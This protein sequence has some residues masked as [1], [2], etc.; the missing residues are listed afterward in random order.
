[1]MISEGDRTAIDRKFSRGLED[2]V[3]L[4][5]FVDGSD[6]SK[7]T[8]LLAREIADIHPKV[9]FSI[10]DSGGSGQ[11]LASQ[12]KVDKF[13]TVMVEK[14]G[15]DR[16][17]YLGIPKQY[18]LPS[19]TDAVVELSASSAKLSPKAKED[20]SKVR[21]RISVK[22]FVLTTCPYCPGVAR[23]AYRAAI[24]SK[25][26]TAEIIDSSMFLDLATRHS[27]MGVPKTVIN[28]SI[29]ITGI[30]DDVVFFEKL[31]EADVSLLDSIYQ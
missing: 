30:V 22:V 15:F 18:E 2:D 23:L 27:V 26:V 9:A 13:P 11:T 14:G 29:D 20:L 24:G 12:R 5:V 17:R 3:L 7:A 19:I 8:A 4:R 6:A 25:H 28:D 10:E 21:R 31:R 1:M 16:I